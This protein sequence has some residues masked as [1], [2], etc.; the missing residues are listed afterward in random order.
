MIDVKLLRLYSNTWDHLTVCKQ[1]SSCSFKNVSV[2]CVY[3]AYLIYKYK[4]DLALNHLQWYAIYPNQPIKMPLKSINW[5]RYLLVSNDIP[6]NII[7]L[8][9]YW[10]ANRLIKLVLQ[11]WKKSETWLAQLRLPILAFWIEG[12]WTFFEE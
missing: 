8:K 9:I 1:M 7:M 12:Q 11:T 4:E 6:S 10:A 5:I 2:K 3:K